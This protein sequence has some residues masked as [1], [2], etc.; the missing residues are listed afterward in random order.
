[1]RSFVGQAAEAMLPGAD[2]HDGRQRRRHAPPPFAV[3]EDPHGQADDDREVEIDAGQME[4]VGEIVRAAKLLQQRLECGVGQRF[5]CGRHFEIH[6]QDFHLTQSISTKTV[7]GILVANPLGT[8]AE[9]DGFADFEVR[10]IVPTRRSQAVVSLMLVDGILLR[11][12]L[13]PAAR[14]RSIPCSLFIQAPIAAG[15]SWR[16]SIAATLFRSAITTTRAA[17][18]SAR[19]ASSTTIASRPAA[20]SAAT[21]TA[22]WKSSLM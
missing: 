2:Q 11:R 16:G 8:A 13:S 4:P 3:L 1:M 9:Y 18:I 12:R 20:A 22:I 14:S 19:F 17:T 7:E 5:W 10:G 6:R 15:R 21:R